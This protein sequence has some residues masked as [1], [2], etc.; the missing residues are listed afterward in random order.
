[1]SKLR[2]LEWDSDFL[3]LNTYR[4]DQDSN[5]SDEVHEC[6]RALEDVRAELTYIFVPPGHDDIVREWQQ[7][8]ARLV[9]TKIT[10]H[11]PVSDEHGTAAAGVR[12]FPANEQLPAALRDIA[13][14]SGRHSRF[15][16]D[17]EMPNGTYERLYT[18]WLDRSVSREI[19]D[20]VFVTES[21]GNITG[22]VTVTV[23][24]DTAVIGLIAVDPSAQGGGIG[25]R[26]ID[27]VFHYAHSKSCS[28]VQVATQS[29][30]TG[31]CRFYERNGFR[32]LSRQMILHYWRKNET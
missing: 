25:S 5:Y 26:L 6:I 22:F 8:G 9:D 4:V 2:R 30:N 12:S 7:T 21:D 16:T 32:E 19:A 18:L 13:L 28:E 23:R 15:L 11:A 27:A 17:P 14:V 3:G 1:M 10:Y 24:D 31:A 20:E 29:E